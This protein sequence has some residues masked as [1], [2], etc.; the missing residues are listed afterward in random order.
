MSPINMMP[1]HVLV[2]F[3]IKEKSLYCGNKNNREKG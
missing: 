1:G 2:A 3:F